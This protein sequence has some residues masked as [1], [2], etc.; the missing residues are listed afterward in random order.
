[1]ADIWGGKGITI[2]KCAKCRKNFDEGMY[3]GICPN[4]GHFN[5]RQTE[6]DVSRYFSATFEDDRK[7]STSGQAAKQHEQLH[8]AYDSV[9]MHKPGAGSHEK[10]HE[11]YDKYN[12]HRQGQRLPAG[13]QQIQ[14]AHQGVPLG[15]PNPYQSGQ[16]RTYPVGNTGASG[17]KQYGKAALYGKEKEKNIVTP[18][19][20]LIAVLAVCVTVLCGHLKTQ[21]LE[22][23]YFTLDVEE[24][25]AQAGE[26][27]EINGYLLMVDTAKVVDTSAVEGMPEGEKLV[28][29]TVAVQSAGGSGMDEKS[30]EVYVSDGSSYKPLLNDYTVLDILYDGDYSMGEDI[31]NKYSLYGYAVAKG[32]SGECYFLVEENAEE[33]S[34]SF[35][36][37]RK[38]DGLYILQKRVS[39]PLKLEEAEDEK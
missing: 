2:M 36:E 6:Y 32:K 28:V 3:S 23:L 35:E 12:M 26:L 11:M 37:G 20:I 15:K 7:T 4:C 25:T 38:E 34:I 14:T 17:Q 27:F 18:V 33:I 29:V 1:M 9:N 22:K 13:N 5:N 10:L 16:N 21:S 30:G 39:V 8:R 31:F 24:L 19:C